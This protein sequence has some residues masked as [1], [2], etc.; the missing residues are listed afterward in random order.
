[1]PV[2]PTIK[3]IGGER[4]A[5]LL[6]GIKNKKGHEIAVEIGFFESAKYPDGTSVPYVASIHEFGAPNRNI[7]PRPFFRNCL[8]KIEASTM[9]IVR[10]EIDPMTMTVEN[11]TIRRV[12]I[13]A[14][15]ILRQSIVDLDKPPLAE[16]TIARRKAAGKGKRRNKKFAMFNPLIDTGTLRRSVTWRTRHTKAGVRK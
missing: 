4:L 1:M 8:D 15:G 12:G 10:A 13:A 2:K 16:S 9:A 3:T 14:A 6:Q 7:P 5:S 11:D